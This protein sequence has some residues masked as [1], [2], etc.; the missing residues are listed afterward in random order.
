MALTDVV[1]KNAKFDPSKSVTKLHDE[2]SM[3]VQVMKNGSKY[4]RL[5]YSYAGR[6]KTLALGVYPEI[7]LKEAREKR[8]AARKLLERGIDPSEYK[9]NKKQ[10]IIEEAENSFSAIAVEWLEKY[11]SKWSEGHANHK[12]RKLELYVI[13]YLGNK[14]IKQISSKDI[15]EV[16]RL[17]EVRGI[18]ETAHRTKNVCSEVFR[19]AIATGRAENDPCQALRGAL[20]PSNPKHMATITSPK[21]VGA[22]LRAI[23]S[24][25]GSFTVL[26]A[27]KLTPLVFLRPGELRQAEWSEIDF[28][29]ARWKIPA[30]KMKMK[31]AHIIPLSKQ[32]LKILKDIQPLTGHWKYVFPSERGKDRPMSN[33]TIR[34]ALRRMDY[35]N[36]DMSAHGF[37]AMASTLLHEKGYRSDIIEMQLAHAERNTV[38]AAYNHAEYLE[39]RTKMMQEW[40]DYLDELKNS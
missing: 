3:Y 19:Y 37:R 27:L 22:L 20:A 13:P 28:D 2:K 21:A 29:I 14:A 1:I 26:Y 40:A 23:D 15:L 32:A 31:R 17:L 11:K 25:N 30:S 24:Y 39:E 4:F 36:D 34:A 7:S 6:R 16:L 12:W 9:K 5:D 10:L 8:D 38:K 18:T 35:S 33:G